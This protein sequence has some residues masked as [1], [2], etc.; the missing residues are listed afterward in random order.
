[1]VVYDVGN[2]ASFRGARVS[3][4]R[5]RHMARPGSV[6]LL[7]GNRCSDPER[8]VPT[9]AGVAL[10]RE[11]GCR[12]FETDSDLAYGHAAVFS[13]LLRLCT[14]SQ[15]SSLTT[16]DIPESSFSAAV[17]KPKQHGAHVRGSEGC[18]D[19]IGGLAGPEE[20]KNTEHKECEQNHPTAHDNPDFLVL[21]QLKQQSLNQLSEVEEFTRREPDYGALESRRLGLVS[22]NTPLIL[23]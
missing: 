10:A 22:Q 17:F 16:E 8:V 15:V 1:M 12:Y 11:H 9:S 5:I 3:L 7:V 23:L 4:G 6:L 19:S 21:Q 13:A 2:D 14:R 18:G 20:D